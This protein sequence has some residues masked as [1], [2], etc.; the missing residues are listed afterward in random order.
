MKKHEVDAGLDAGSLALSPPEFPT[1]I[2]NFSDFISACL[3]VFG[4]KNAVSIFESNA[5]KTLTFKSLAQESL[6][7][8]GILQ[9]AGLR[10]GDRVAILS[11]SSIEWVTHFF[12]TLFC[13]GVVV[14]LDIKLTEAEI[15]HIVRHSGPSFI[16]AS[17]VFRETARAVRHNSERSAK[18]FIID[19][20]GIHE[21][22]LS[23]AF[24][25]VELSPRDL[26]VICYTSGT[27]G[28]PKGVEIP[29]EVFL[30][31][32]KSLA[33]VTQYL[34]EKEVMLTILPLNHLYGL[35]GG[36]LYSLRNGMELIFV[37]EM[38][39]QAINYC[40]RERQVTQLL[41]VPLY[42]KMVMRGISARILEDKGVTAYRAL[43][44]LMKTTKTIRSTRYKDFLFSGIREGL[45]GKLKRFICGG[46]EL[47]AKVFDFF[48]A[49]NIPV[50][51][52]YGLTETGPV[53]ATNVPQK[54]RRGSVGQPIPGVE[55]KIVDGEILTRGPHL[56]SGYFRDPQLTQETF[57]EDGWFRTGDLGYLDEQGFL[58]V[59]GRKKALI[60]LSSGKKIHPEEVEAVI[61]QNRR[62][63]MV[64]VLGLKT[65]AGMMD[66]QVTA[67]ILPTDDEIAKCDGDVQKI[68]ATLKPE[69]EHQCENLAPYKRPVQILIRTQPFVMTTSLKI[70]RDILLKE[71]TEATEDTP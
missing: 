62:V 42:V 59:N 52:G 13:G 55:V 39:P 63:R 47:D 18:V 49:I 51:I 33:Q 40:L 10:K 26:A 71:L 66:E 41:A 48:N 43:R 69:I 2:R 8:A 53:I 12:A 56:T 1:Q 45:G 5:W 17:Q 35:S 28:A 22:L 34:G 25:P 31:Q 68:L 9:S 27:S 15:G 57:T 21:G 64:C 20:P 46:S 6:R 32:A 30:F 4:E 29:T 54:F 14:P 58:Y 67:V 7:V 44:A 23:K 16:L 19:E 3:H 61:S 65:K 38:T 60:V 37:H 24:R 70:K 11:S 36:L 50:Y